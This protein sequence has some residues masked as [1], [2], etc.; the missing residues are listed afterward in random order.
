[1]KVIGIIGQKAAGKT[2]IADYIAEKTGAKIH[3]YAEILDDVLN[4][5]HLPITNINEIKLVALRNVFGENTLPKALRKKIMAEEAPFVIITGIRFENELNDVRSYHGSK[6]LYVES[7]IQ[8]RFERQRERNQKADDT[9][10]SFDQFVSLEA[11]ATEKQVKKLGEKA[12][13]KITN[14]GSEQELFSQIDGIL[15]QIN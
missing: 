1:M 6:L 9:S 8:L 15:Q 5:L 4:V 2:T 12:D 13:Y 7:D 14:N 10:M 11:D 3:R